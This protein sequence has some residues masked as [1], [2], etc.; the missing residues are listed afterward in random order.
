M[1][2]TEPDSSVRKAPAPD[3]SL[4]ASDGQTVTR[5]QFR[6]KKHL[7]LVFLP[8][9][10]AAQAHNLAETLHGEHDDFTLANAAVYAI[11]PRDAVPP[12]PLPVLIDANNAIRAEYAALLPIDQRPA[13]TDP[14]LI[15]LNRYGIPEFAGLGLFEGDSVVEQIITYVWSLEYQ[16]SL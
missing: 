14:F 15:L 1:H 8:D 6:Q 3:F 5:V 4:P 12:S 2:W 9:P 10:D 16:C 13:D 7:V 11:S